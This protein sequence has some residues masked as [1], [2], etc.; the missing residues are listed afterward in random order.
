MN[1]T[2]LS[3]CIYDFANSSYSAVIASVIFPV[4]Y[5]TYVVGNQQGEGD[6]W[7]G[8]AISLSMAL[9]ALSSP[10]IGGIA[11]YKGIRKRMLFIYTIFCIISVSL[12]YF[13]DKGMILTGFILIVI[14]NIGLEGGI[15]FYNAFLPEIADPSYQGRVSSWGYALG[16]AGSILSLLIALVL[17]SKGYIELTWPLTALF[18]LI[19]SIP[20]FVFL[21]PDN[22]RESGIRMAA[23]EGFL[24]CINTL[25]VI[26]LQRDIKRFLLSYLLYE[27]AV[28]TVIVFSSVFGATTLHLTY[29]ELFGVY[30]IV[31]FT[32][33]AGSL[34]MAKPTDM[35]G[36]KRVITL[37]LILWI[38]VCGATYFVKSSLQFFIIASIAGL[39]LGT[40]QAASRAFFARFIPNGY[41][42][43]YFGIYCLVGKSSAIIGPLLF[44]HISSSTGSQ[45]AAVIA[46]G[47]LFLS[48]LVVLAGVNEP[49]K[50][51]SIF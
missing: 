5:T 6:L 11:D 41:E 28:N 50:K 39:G 42:S 49:S 23:M 7:W 9:V 1:K 21:P 35:W 3:W 29:G 45:R 47:L 51:D 34:T 25:K 44:G 32:A 26:L 16:Y 38:C 24:Q 31:Q 14:A 8:R 12:L 46:V 4:Y 10:F 15:V 17:L 27:D 18:F 19:F 22:K 48:G 37:S 43:E 30:L 20:A 36:P 2:I 40:I 13:L 33:L